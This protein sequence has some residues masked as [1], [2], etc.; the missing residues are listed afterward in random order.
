MGFGA[1]IPILRSFDERRTR[2]FY[3]DF[4]GFEIGFEHRFAANMPLYMEVR[5]GD[6]AL[7][8]SEHYGDGAPGMAVRIA[9]DDVV[10]YAAELQSRAFENARPGAPVTQDWG[11]IELGVHDPSHNRLVFYTPV[12]PQGAG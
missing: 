2:A 10:A 4:L 12:P 7:H 5:R 6:C 8:L 3:L 9:V 11:I 1:P